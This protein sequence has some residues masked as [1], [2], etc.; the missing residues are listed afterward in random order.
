VAER[1]EGLLALSLYRA[2][3]LATALSQRASSSAPRGASRSG[4]RVDNLVKEWRRAVDNEILDRQRSSFPP[5][6][7]LTKRSENVWK[8][9][10]HA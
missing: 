1:S 4:F 8:N 3:W 6:A 9:I 2:R 7:G 10:E 5:T